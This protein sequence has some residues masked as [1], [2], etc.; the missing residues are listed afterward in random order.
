MVLKRHTLR[1]SRGIR[2]CST[3]GNQTPYVYLYCIKGSTSKDFHLKFFSLYLLISFREFPHVCFT[4][5][6]QTFRDSPT[7]TTEPVTLDLHTPRRTPRTHYL[8]TPCTIKDARTRF[9]A[10]R[11]ESDPSESF[12]RSQ[13]LEPLDLL[14]S[15]R[16]SARC[17][18]VLYAIEKQK[19]QTLPGLNLR[20]LA[21][22]A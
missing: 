15:L 20:H 11:A 19:R 6:W 7:D 17:A 10:V 3:R 14:Y 22:H 2:L 18:E 16:I 9:P 13:H 5:T 8:T 1:N 12:Y 21:L 4:Y